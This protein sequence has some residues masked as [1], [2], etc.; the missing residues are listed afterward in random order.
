MLHRSSCPIH[1][2]LVAFAAFAAAGVAACSPPR[3]GNT[4]GGCARSQLDIYFSPM[5]SAFDGVHT[6]QVPA[7]VN[8]IDPAK[9]TWNISNPAL[10]I[11]QP[12]AEGVMIT[13]QRVGNAT[14]LASAG[15]SCGSASLLVS[16]ASPDDWLIGSNRYNS[17][18]SLMGGAVTAPT[19]GGAVEAACTSCHGDTAT[20][21]PF[22]TVSHTPRQTGGFSDD[23][24]IQIFTEGS[25]PPYAYFDDTIVPRVEWAT[26]HRWSMTPVQAKGMVVYLR[27][28][29][30]E[31]QKGSRGDF[32]IRPDGGPGPPPGRPGDAGGN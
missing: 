20:N 16:P 31:R 5:Y 32:G 15:T 1:P 18:V 9:V 12:N 22:R 28:L 24:L 17:G 8:G 23:Q 13:V 4:N 11:L 14:I 30:P 2:R 19:D 10:A 21:G 25:L 3:I 7:M 26:F 29:V 27:S 6:F